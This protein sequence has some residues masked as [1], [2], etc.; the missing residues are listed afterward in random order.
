MRK[1][2][3]QVNCLLGGVD[4]DGSSKLYWMDY[5]ATMQETKYGVQGHAAH[6]T[7]STLDRYFKVCS[8]P[9]AGC[10]RHLRFI[11]V[12]C[13]AQDDMSLEEGEEVVQKCI[14]EVGTRF[15]ISQPKWKLTI[16]TSEGIETEIVAPVV[17]LTD[18]IPAGGQE[19]VA[20]AA[21]AAAGGQ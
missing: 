13:P 8:P 7:L 9:T 5:L 15:L 10:P 3:Y 11:R 14:N 1:A 12:M 18:K 19:A 6:F 21:A 20:A 17:D 16:V 2:P 4:A